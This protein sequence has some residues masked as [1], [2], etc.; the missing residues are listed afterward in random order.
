MGKANAGVMASLDEPLLIVVGKN[1]TTT[2][3]AMSEA[4]FKQAAVA[5]GWKGLLIVSD[6]GHNEAAKSAELNGAFSRLLR[7]A[8][9]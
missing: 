3:P 5:A 2:K 8:Q 1:D 9:K 7:R 4:L 6:A